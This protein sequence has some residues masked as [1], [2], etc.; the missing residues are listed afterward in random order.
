MDQFD[1]NKLL[2]TEDNF[3][4]WIKESGGILHTRKCSNIN[5]IDLSRCKKNTLVCLT[6]YKQIVDQFFTTI[7][8]KFTHKIILI[9]LETDFFEMEEKYLNHHLLNHWF[10]WNKQYEHPKLTCIPIGLNADRHLE[11]MKT[12]VSEKNSVN[13]DKLFAVNLSVNTNPAR[14]GLVDLAQ[15]DWIDFCTF[16]DSIPFSS[17]RMQFSYIEREIKICVTDPECYKQMTNFKFI[18]SPAGAGLDCHRTWEALYLGTIPIVLS[19]S[20]DELFTDLPVVIVKSW[21]EITEKFLAEKYNEVQSNWE[22]KKYDVNKLYFEYWKK[23]IERKI[24]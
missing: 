2:L 12:Y 8:Q 6:G 11:S 5:E 10:T 7:I 4:D 16:I 15:T 1:Y 18:L 21:E 14:Q 22:N 20:I 17:I 19:S 23:M 13:R 24:R 9:T 3:V